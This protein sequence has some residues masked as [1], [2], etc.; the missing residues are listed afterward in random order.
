[1]EGHGGFEH[2]LHGLRVVDILEQKYPDFP[3]LNLSWEVKESI[4][5]HISP[6]D[7]TSTTTE[8]N[9]DEMPLLEAQ[10]VDKADSIA[11]DNHD[12]G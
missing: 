12:L 6:Y 5:K 7:H 10:I 8:Y 2:N 4:V 1:M 11:Y 9:I 3:G